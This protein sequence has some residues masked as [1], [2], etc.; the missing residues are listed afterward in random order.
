MAEKNAMTAADYIAQREKE[1]RPRRVAE[2]SELERAQLG[3][4]AVRALQDSEQAQDA[5]AE[6]HRAA[7]DAAAKARAVVAT[8]PSWIEPKAIGWDHRGQRVEVESEN[9]PLPLGDGQRVLL[10]LTRRKPRPT[11]GTMGNVGSA[12]SRLGADSQTFEPAESRWIACGGL[13]R[14]PA[15]KSAVVWALHRPV[16]VSVASEDLSKG[17]T[18]DAPRQ[19]GPGFVGEITVHFCNGPE[20]NL[21]LQPG[22]FVA[23]A[24]LVD[25]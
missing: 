1:S 21:L 14:V 16:G 19:Y 17:Y 10:R 3:P 8:L 18:L 22:H 11:P 15:G 7:A 13:L 25:S 2:L 4:A 6:K 24:E 12:L 23:V 9:P 5:I 20:R